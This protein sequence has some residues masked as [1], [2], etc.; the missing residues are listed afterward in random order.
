ML[1]SVWLAAIVAFLKLSL[2]SWFPGLISRFGACVI[3]LG[4]LKFEPGN[5]SRYGG[6]GGAAIF[7]TVV[8]ISKGVSMFA[9]SF[10]VPLFDSPNGFTA[11]ELSLWYSD[12]KRMRR[13]RRHFVV[14][15]SLFIVSR[16]SV[17]GRERE[18]TIDWTGFLSL[19]RI[20]CYVF[21]PLLAVTIV[22][23][24]DK[25]SSADSIVPQSVVPA[26]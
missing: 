10:K 24:R 4:R 17:W 16:L 3:T 7:D 21:L 12:D 13:S 6:G 5:G 18:Q 22:A 9:F 11:T 1:L 26:L 15:S 8:V 2:F 20:Y 25:T 23:A 19:P 14:G